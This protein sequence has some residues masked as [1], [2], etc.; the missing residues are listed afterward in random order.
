MMRTCVRL[1][2]GRWRCLSK[3]QAFTGLFYVGI[4]LVVIMVSII[5][6]RGGEINYLDSDAT[7]HTLLTM[8]AYDETPI[9]QHKFLPIVSLGGVDNKGISWGATIPDK[10][11]NFYYTSF[12]PAGFVLP[13]LFIKV[14]R[15]PINETSLYY[16]NTLLFAISAVLWAF[17][18]KMIYKSEKWRWHIICIGVLTY[19]FSPELF[20]GMGIVY[21][22]QSIMQVMLIAQFL[23]YYQYKTKNSKKGK[24]AFYLITLIIPYI[25]WTGYVANLGFALFELG[26][27][28][29]FDL[30]RAWKNAIVIGAITVTSFGLFTVHYLSVV[31][32]S[33]FFL[34]LKNRFFARNIA[35]STL[36][37]DVFG[38]YLKSFLL[39]WILLFFL[40]IWNIIKN[41]KIELKNKCILFVLAFPL[42]ENVV[43]KEHALSYS[44]DRMKMVFILSY[45]ICELEAQILVSY[46]K[47]NKAAFIIIAIVTVICCFGNLNYYR[48]DSKYIWDITYRETN[49]KI[50]E[51]IN[52]NYWNSVL[53]TNASVRGYL[54][55]LFNRGIYE[56]GDIDSV[57][58]IALQKGKRYAIE[59]KTLGA[60]GNMYQL[61][62]AIVYD[63][64]AD[65]FIYIK[66]RSDGT[67]VEL[68]NDVEEYNLADL[69]DENWTSGYSNV[70][71]VLLFYY[72]EELLN[73]LRNG[74]FVSTGERQFTIQDIKYDSQWIKVTVEGDASSCKY[75]AYISIQ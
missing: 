59:L 45:L 42:L 28:W 13:Y 55:L 37:T 8:Q 38:S 40:I 72:E 68:N 26:S 20:H 44:Y 21:W 67:I 61:T 46:E 19:I 4:I 39:L 2:E 30:K 1:R 16:F 50:S 70:G 3:N 34:A 73:N 66:L 60:P 18:L 10:E 63:A 7:W 9:S 56:W 62:G 31:A 25:E 14:F 32:A 69:T 27:D 51:Y 36:L 49:K 35:S 23:T 64:V 22:H 5:K 17:F 33:D 47:R 65:K 43:M 57:R 74:T 15:L 58:D 11:G 48:K 29:K 24:I 71:N 6:F 53:T 75:P 12:S 52:Q 41:G 54:N